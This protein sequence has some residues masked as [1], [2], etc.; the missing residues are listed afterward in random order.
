[1]LKF[2]DKKKTRYAVIKIKFENR[3][4]SLNGFYIQLYNYLNMFEKTV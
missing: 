1:M 4:C 2:T 3:G